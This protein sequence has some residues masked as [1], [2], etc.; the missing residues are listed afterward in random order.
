VLAAEDQVVSPTYVPDLVNASLDLLV[1]G[2]TG[3]WH[4]AH[5]DAVSWADLARLAAWTAGLDPAQVQ[6]LPAAALGQLAARPR[7]AVLSSERGQLMTPLQSALER[8]LRDLDLA[9]PPPA[10][11]FPQADHAPGGASGQAAVPAPT[12]MG[13][14]R[15]MPL[16][17]AAA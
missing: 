3:L 7:Y 6:A 4:L 11:R 14:T 2:E 10:R 5:P 13:G 8:Y 9:R 16:P 12:P 17:P 1:D 15:T